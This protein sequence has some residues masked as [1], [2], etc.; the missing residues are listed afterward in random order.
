MGHAYRQFDG[1]SFAALHY[2][3]YLLGQ[4]VQKLCI[5]HKGALTFQ[6]VILHDKT[7]AKFNFPT[8][9]LC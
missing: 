6:I 9:F 1:Q 2:L 5:K 4:L 3:T 7:Y 8:L